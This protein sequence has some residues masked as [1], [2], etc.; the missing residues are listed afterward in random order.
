MTYEKTTKPRE[1]FS[2]PFFYK[3][4]LRKV[5]GLFPTMIRSRSPASSTA[6]VCC[7][8]TPNFPLLMGTAKQVLFPLL[9]ASG[10]SSSGFSV[11]FILSFLS[12]SSFSFSFSPSRLS[13]SCRASSCRAKSAMARRV[14][15]RIWTSE[16]RARP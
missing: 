15:C 2:D 14:F 1:D 10:D 12:Q 8:G 9:L 7:Q 5:S 13:S 4:P 16:S 3:S 11:S 6:F